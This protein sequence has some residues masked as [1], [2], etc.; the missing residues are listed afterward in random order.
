[1]LPA[2]SL[3]SFQHSSCKVS[4]LAN[5]FALTHVTGAN[6]ISAIIDSFVVRDLGR[7]FRL[8]RPANGVAR[9]ARANVEQAKL[10][11]N[12]R[13][14]LSNVSLRICLKLATVC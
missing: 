7:A 1:M 4:S 8:V 6:C 14:F 12:G 2:A 3:C 10:A 11:T 9:P 13:M 5:P